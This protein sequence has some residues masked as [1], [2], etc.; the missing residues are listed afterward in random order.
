[1]MKVDTE[2][3]VIELLKKAGYWDNDDAW[4][5]YGDQDVN[6]SII[7]GQSSKPDV[8]LVE[9]I[10]NSV[11]ARLILECQLRGIDPAEPAAPKSI[12]S[13]VAEFFEDGSKSATAGLVREWSS[14]KRTKVSHGI[15]LA[16]TGNKPSNGNPC[17]T[18]SDCGEGQTPRALPDTIL[19][20]LKKNKIKINFVQGKFN[21][22]GSGVLEYCG[23]KGLQLVI[24]RR[25]PKLLEN[26]QTDP[27]DSHW[28]FTIVRHEDPISSRRLSVYTYLAPVGSDSNPMKG[29][30][31]TFEADSMPIFPEKDKPY[32][33]SSEYGTLIKLYEYSTEGYSASN[34]LRKGLLDHLDLRLANVALPVRLHECRG[35]GGKSGSFDTTL[36]GIEVRLDDNRADNL[37][38]VFSCSMSIDGQQIT[39][40]IYVFKKGKDSAYRRNEGVIFTHNG[41]THGHF[42]KSFFGTKS[43]NMGYLKNS[44]LVILNCDKIQKRPREKLFMPSRDGLRKIELRRKIAEELAYILKSHPGL[45][46]LR[47]KRQREEAGE[48]LKDSKPLATVLSSLIKKS[49]K[50]ASLFNPGI[51]L[52]DP[53]KSLY[54]DESDDPFKGKRFPDIFKLKDVEF[55]EILTRNCPIN[56]RPRITFETDVE[57]NYFNRKIHPGVF[58]LCLEKNAN[59]VRV[60]TATMNL[61]NGL[62]TL[63]L[64]IPDDCRVGDELNY[65]ARV[66]DYTRADPF[67]NRFNLQIERDQKKTKRINQ[68]RRK[69]PGD[70]NGKKREKPRGIDLPNIVQVFEEAND[71]NKTWDGMEPPFNEYSALRVISHGGD[72]PNGNSPLSYDFYINMDNFYLKHDIKKSTV[73]P[74]LT[75]TQ[76]AN[77]LVLI[78]VAMIQHDLEKN[79]GKNANVDADLDSEDNNRETIED[80]IESTSEAIAYVVLPI[81]DI[82]SDLTDEDIV[83]DVENDEA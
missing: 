4:R 46:A 56:V 49:P 57:S 71:G 53:F 33:R 50:I 25:A 68:K 16:A 47:E 63:N 65:I 17:F 30:V 78:G 75:R 77:A 3:D 24:S 38:D 9:K 26:K 28:G 81:I 64:D 51:R 22:G 8:A 43:V 31:L 12:R 10:V 29:E 44:I 32:V 11:D 23:D 59:E 19:S 48:R 5:Y 39:G 62:A 40:S 37:E 20:L 82:L 34:I 13:A 15:T 21:M 61:A 7:A 74:D 52:S 67:V 14:S 45:R 73:E 36:S 60:P 35:Y 27:T 72:N 70:Q 54:Y 55:G 80:R 41:Q 1:M 66:T 79:K 6:Y 69:P 2:D 76:F 18:I 58:E 42:S 83:F